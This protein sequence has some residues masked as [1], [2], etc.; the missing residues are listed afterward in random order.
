MSPLRASFLLC[1]AAIPARA[2]QV[3]INEIHY[4]NASTDT[5]EGLEVAGPAG[6]SLADYDVVFYNGTGGMP[7]GGTLRL[8]GTIPNQSGGAG[9]MW[10]PVAGIQNDK[11]GMVLY[12][13]PSQTVVQRISYEGSFTAVGGVANGQVLPDI[14]VAE[15]SSTLATQ[16]LQLIGTGTQLSHFTWTTPRAASPGSLN[17]GQ[18]PHRHPRAQCHAG[19][20]PRAVVRR[21][22]DH[23]QPHTFSR[24]LGP[25]DLH[26]LSHHA[27]AARA[28]LTDQRGPHGH[29]LRFHYGP[30]RWRGGRLPGN[31][32][33][34]PAAG[35]PVPGRGGNGANHGEMVMIMMSC[36]RCVIFIHSFC[37]S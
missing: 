17:A 25:A 31:R 14:G 26:P 8:S 37:C 13:W 34:R 2:Q 21:P 27:G 30:H 23:S 22:D 20:L 1:C 35:C 9:A 3:F 4:D 6:T 7:Y 33:A 36:V 28:A 24:T 12:H 10:F 11:D 5:N 16:S 29:R 15:T 32:R 18:T 19:L